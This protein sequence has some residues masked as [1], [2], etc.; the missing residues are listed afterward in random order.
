MQPLEY[1][2]EMRQMTIVFVN[3]VTTDKLYQHQ[4]GLLQKS[5][6]IVY[7]HMKKNQGESFA[8]AEYIW[9][10]CRHKYHVCNNICIPSG[11]L[12]KIFMFDKV[13]KWWDV[14]IFCF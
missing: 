3:L 8:N 2:S 9:C 10:W 5:F 6:D 12:N 1:L 14:L 4:I 13:E 11:C 7:T